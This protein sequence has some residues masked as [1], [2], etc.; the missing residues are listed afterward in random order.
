MSFGSSSK[1]NRDLTEGPY[2]GA[3][4]NTTNPPSASN[5]FATINDLVNNNGIFSSANSGKTVSAGF[6]SKLTDSYTWQH[7]TADAVVNINA[8]D[9]VGNK[10]AY[11]AFQVAGAQQAA[12]GWDE[13]LEEFKIS[14]VNFGISHWFRYKPSAASLGLNG[15]TAVGQIDFSGNQRFKVRGQGTTTTVNT[16]K[17]D[18]T[19]VA[20]EILLDNGQRSFGTGI[21]AS[22]SVPSFGNWYRTAGFSTG[23]A[24]YGYGGV[25]TTML[26]QHTG[27]GANP[28][29]LSVAFQNAVA[30]GTARAISGVATGIAS[31]PTNI[32]GLYGSSRNGSQFSIAID[33]EITGGMTTP[34][35][36]YTAALRGIN[37]GNLDADGY[38]SYNLA[39]YG[40]T[41][42]IYTSDIVGTFGWGAGSNGAAGST[43]KVVGGKFQTTGTAGTGDRLALWV[44]AANNGLVVIGNDDAVGTSLVQVFG[45]IESVGAGFGLVLTT[46]DGLKR[47]KYEADNTDGSLVKTLLP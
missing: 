46:Q 15:N 19:G 3:E 6:V 42:T 38:G 32:T 16:R 13:G 20:R 12:I 11:L 7:D 1:I 8:V 27:G 22:T 37:N 44:P 4:N 5:P 33:G 34:S 47:Y 28:K 30:T 41:G 14:T 29:A 45:N 23:F 40:A 26:I 25:S 24:F 21:T 39:Q 10:D 36:T 35:T 43:G 18:G 17:E 9:G 2:Q 31:G